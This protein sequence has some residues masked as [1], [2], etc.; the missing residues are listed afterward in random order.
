MSMDWPP[1][2]QRPAAPSGEAHVWRAELDRGGWPSH[3]LLPPPERERAES[4]RR[5]LSRDRWVASRWALRG[6]LARYLDE[7][8]AAVALRLGERGKPALADPAATLRFNLSHSGSLAL[9]AVTEG[10]EVGVDVEEIDPERD[11][12]PLAERGLDSAAAAAVRA[13]PPEA[14][15]TAFHQAWARQEA[16]VKCLGGALGAPLPPGPVA[17]SALGAGPGYAAALAVAGTEPIPHRRFS[18]PRNG[19]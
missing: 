16:V 1:G 14:R 17:V 10:R 15:A 19:R 3:E 2:P 5:P 8:P 9:I 4:M 13:A 12:V 18:F 7:D 11:V 6:V